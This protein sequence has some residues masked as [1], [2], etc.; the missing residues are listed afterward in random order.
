MTTSINTKQCLCKNKRHFG[1]K[2]ESRRHF[3]T[4]FRKKC[5]RSGGNE[6]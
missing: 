4:S 3:N 2:R 6:L 5:R 1:G